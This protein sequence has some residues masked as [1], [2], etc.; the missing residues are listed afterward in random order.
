MSGAEGRFVKVDAVMICPHFDIWF[1][2]SICAHDDWM[3]TRCSACGAPLD[4]KCGKDLREANGA[5]NQNRQ[6][7]VTGRVG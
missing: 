7:G 6:G 1:D 5:D 3:H 4:G 2:R